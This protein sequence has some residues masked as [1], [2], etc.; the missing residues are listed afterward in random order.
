MSKG[1]RQ[2]VN[3]PQN[4]TKKIEESLPVSPRWGGGGGGG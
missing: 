1:P 2:T 3:A 4:K